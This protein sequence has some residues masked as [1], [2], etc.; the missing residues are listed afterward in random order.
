MTKL[1]N[2]G[3][4]ES[5]N[6]TY[7]LENLQSL[8]NYFFT[9][10]VEE[11]LIEENS[12]LDQMV[13]SKKDNLLYDVVFNDVGKTNFDFKMTLKDASFQDVMVLIQSMIN[14]T[15]FDAG[16]EAPFYFEE[17]SDE[18]TAIYNPFKGKDARDDFLLSNNNILQNPIKAY[19]NYNIAKENFNQLLQDKNEKNKHIVKEIGISL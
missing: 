10:N 6:N 19:P 4:N 8:K 13:I 3:F 9:N 14:E 12:N 1:I 11:N 18:S 17:I 2:I 7:I 15:Y 16:Y 5:Q